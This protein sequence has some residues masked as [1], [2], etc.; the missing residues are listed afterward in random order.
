[1]GVVLKF[2]PEMVITAPTEALKGPKPVIEGEGNTVK[3]EVLEMVTPLTANEILPVVAPTGTIVVMLV[4]VDDRTNASVLLNFKTLLAG[5]ELKFAPAIITVAPMAPLPGVIDE[6]DGDP[7]TLKFDALVTV[8]PLV[9]TAIGPVGAPMGTLVVILVDDDVVTIAGTPLNVTELFA[10]VSLKSVPEIITVAPAAPL[11]GLNPVRVGVGDTV[12]LF[13]LKIVIP[14]SVNETFPVVAPT[15]TVVVILVEVDAVTVAVTP[16]KVK[17]LFAGIVLK[18]EPV[19]IIVALT[20]PLAGLKP[21]IDGVGKTMKSGV[22]DNVTPLTVTAIDP[23]VAPVGTEVARLLAVAEVT[24][25]VIP[26]KDTIL[27]AGVVLKLVPVIVIKVPAAPL[28]GSKPV[29]VGEGKIVKL[30]AL[31]IVTPLTVIE[32]LPVVAPFGTIAVIVVALDA[33]TVADT[34]LNLTILLADVV[35][36]FVPEI[37]T[38]APSAPLDGLNPVIAGVGRTEKTEALVSVTPLTS[39]VI[40][41]VDEPAGTVVVMLFVEEFVTTA[42]VLLN[43]TI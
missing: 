24:T 10:G 4:A 7:N 9:V 14:L 30:V 12:K 3:S 27:F 2:V 42:V 6:I 32:I 22:L 20:A 28:P 13:V 25:A 8:T 17:M 26:L 19:I 34:S 35:L 39:M 33:V 29:N 15:G 37:V 21:A 36:K 11:D 41:P 23:V 16:L 5:V 31:E 1:V 38:V 40:F 43:L 18:F